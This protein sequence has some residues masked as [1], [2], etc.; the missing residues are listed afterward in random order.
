MHRI[1]RAAAGVLGGVALG[2]LVLTGCHRRAGYDR[3]R[4]P[5]RRHHPPRSR[6]GLLQGLGGRPG[7]SRG[8]RRP[9]EF[10]VGP[11]DHRDHR[12]RRHQDLRVGPRTRPSEPA[13]VIELLPRSSSGKRPWSC[14]ARDISGT[15]PVARLGVVRVQPGPPGWR[16]ASGAA[17]PGLRGLLRSQLRQ[18][19]RPGHRGYRRPARSPRH[20]AGGVR[21]GPGALAPGQRL[22]GARGLGPAGRDAARHRFRP[23]DPP[24]A[25]R[26]AAAA[27][28]QPAG[29]TRARGRA[30]LHRARPGARAYPAAGTRSARLVLR[31][32]SAGGADR[33]RP[34]YPGQHRKVA[35]GRRAAAAR[36]RAGSGSGLLRR[37]SVMR[38]ED[39][40]EE[41]AAWLRPVRAAEPPAL[42]VIRRR[43]RRR[44]ARQAAGGTAA[45]AAVAGLAVVLS[46]TASAPR[47]PA[48]P[49][50]ASPP[51]GIPVTTTGPRP[52][53]GGYQASAAYTISAPV[54]SLVVASELGE[55][56]ITGSQRST[57]SVTEQIQYSDRPPVMTRTVTGKTL[58]LGYRCPNESKCA[59][60]YDIQ[61]PRDVA[62]QASSANG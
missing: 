52:A 8:R 28:R 39:L 11:R 4:R 34:G 42:P 26:S 49:P 57:V 19:R 12:R 60:S 21:P 29:G 46:A 61:V 20:R 9:A 54:S 23:A 10:L 41:F 14:T 7:R 22:R 56:T 17:E 48:G 25:A 1:R 37:R 16:G 51:S 44:R 36:T 24:G 50:A 32:R 45:L 31:R 38:D 62:V 18:D 6:P 13:G 3:G 27:G 43:L 2:G 53:P 59:A 35:A 47:A 40:R 5:R 58:T 15:E 30:G 33:S 55:V